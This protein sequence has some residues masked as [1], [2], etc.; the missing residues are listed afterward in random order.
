MRTQ[1]MLE[2]SKASLTVVCDKV[3]EIFETGVT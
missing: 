1:R 2:S 3:S